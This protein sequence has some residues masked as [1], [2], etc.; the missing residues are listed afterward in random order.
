LLIFGYFALFA[1]QA[2]GFNLRDNKWPQPST[3]FHVDI[4]GESGLWDT[5]FE[6]AMGKWNSNTSFTFFIVR[7]SLID[8]CQD[9]NDVPAANGVKFNSTIC[10]DAFGS[11]TLAVER[12]WSNST[13]L[14]QSGI[15]FN[16]NKAWDVYDS[17]FNSG[18]FSG[19]IDFRRVAVHELGH[20]LGLNHENTITSIMN[21]IN[22][23]GNTIINPQADDINGVATLYGG[24]G[25]PD[26][27][28]ISPNV[29]NATPL[30]GQ[31]FAINATVKNQGVASSNGTTLRYYRSTNNFISVAD[32]EMGTDSVSGL[33][34]TGTS[35]QSL[36]TS[37]PGVGTLWIGACVDAVSGESS[38][39]NQCSSGVQVT[40]IAD[41]DNDGIADSSD[42]CP[43]ISNANQLDTDSDGTGN[44]C[45]SDDDNDGMPDSFENTF[46]LNPLDAADAA[47]DSDSDGLSNLE[48]YQT[49][50]NPKVNEN[51]VITIIN[52]IL[53]E[54]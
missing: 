44:A 28:V 29:S 42:N 23:T 12:S 41:S 5:A 10:G 38:A 43:S 46:G 13:N 32:T 9:P 52:V 7:G 51:A 48:E 50:R 25:F 4:P 35:T 24:S 2:Y 8:P 22:F 6:A 30:S 3:T 34:A 54:E 45:D 53:I 37:L 33:S 15:V 17:A 1:T 14:V 20:S 27:V 11:T 39:S 36:T 40:V 26:L 18:I 31:S 21:A 16:N 19:V 47:L 49:G